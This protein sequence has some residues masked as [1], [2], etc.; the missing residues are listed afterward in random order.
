M[1]LKASDADGLDKVMKASGTRRLHI[2]IRRDSSRTGHFLVASL[3]QLVQFPRR[4][5]QSIGIT[6]LCPI[7][8]RGQAIESQPEFDRPQV[9]DVEGL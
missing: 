7:L 4:K 3:G 8:T 6:V 2:E 1:V 5:N 9:A